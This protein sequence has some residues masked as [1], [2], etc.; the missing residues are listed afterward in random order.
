MTQYKPGSRWRS[1]VC[2]T[3]VVVVRGSVDDVEIACGGRPMVP[4]D[5]P[6]SEPA[7]ASARDG[8]TQIGKRYTS[9]ELGI[10]LLC[11]KAGAGSLAAN[12]TLLS[13]KEAKP[14]PSSD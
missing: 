11:T 2:T 10:E 1:V 9:E 4:I 7:A 13:L 6:T 12:G 3:E 5:D 14:L 8:G